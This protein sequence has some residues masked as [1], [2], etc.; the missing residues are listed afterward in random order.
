MFVAALFLIAKTWKQP[1]KSWDP[2]LSDTLRY[3]HTMGYSEA[4]RGTMD[5]KQLGG[6]QSI[7]LSEKSQCRN[8][9]YS[10]IP[11]M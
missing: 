6:L 1:K 11:P 8:F 2:E 5:M 7:M 10:V 3:I 4:I 9:T